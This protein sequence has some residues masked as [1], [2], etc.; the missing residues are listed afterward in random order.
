MIADLGRKFETEGP[1]DPDFDVP[2]DTMLTTRFRAAR[3]PTSPRTVCRVLAEIRHLPR[4]AAAII[5]SVKQI[6]CPKRWKRK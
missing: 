4:D 3:Q 2:H 1:F 5:E 6:P